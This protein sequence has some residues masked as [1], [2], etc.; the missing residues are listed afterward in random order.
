MFD[1]IE[2]LDLIK[3]K[4]DY[5][6]GYISLD[7]MAL[8]TDISTATWRRNEDQGLIPARIK[9]GGRLRG[10]PVEVAKTIITNGIA[11]D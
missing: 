8:W 4:L 6:R 11:G 2:R 9:L 10:W 7:E 1:R 5:N 3:E